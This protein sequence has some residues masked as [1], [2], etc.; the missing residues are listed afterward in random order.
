MKK[1]EVILLSLAILMSA[2]GLEAKKKESAEEEAPE[3]HLSAATLSGLALRNIG[4]AINSGRVI[5]FAV[6][7]GKRH[8]Y[9]AAI[10]SGG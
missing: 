5:D 10:A 2:S 1:L 6:T 9:F 7:P 8:R 3:P 4:P